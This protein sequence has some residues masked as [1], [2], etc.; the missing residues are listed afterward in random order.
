M[1][2]GGEELSHSAILTKAFREES[3]EELWKRTR[4]RC[5]I[6]K[7]V[8]E[9]DRG[10]DLKKAVKWRRR[11]VRRKRTNDKEGNLLVERQGLTHG[12]A[13][14]MNPTHHTMYY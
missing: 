10:E 12:H 5:K 8:G 7:A 2:W 14:L 3:L 1:E 9:E 11:N 4:D 13:I 6:K